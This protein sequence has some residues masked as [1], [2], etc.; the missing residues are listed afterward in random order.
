MLPTIKKLNEITLAN[1]LK[2]L[3]SNSYSSDYARTLCEWRKNFN[4]SFQEISKMG[5][6]EKFK[7]LWNFYLTYCESGFKTKRID[8]KQIKIVHN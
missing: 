5:F 7:R 3:E 1:N 2:I 4:E 8:L 6:D